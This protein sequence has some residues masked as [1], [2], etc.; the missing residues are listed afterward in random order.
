[1]NDRPARYTF[2]SSRLAGTI[3]KY[4]LAQAAPLFTYYY[5]RLARSIYSRCLSLVSFSILAPSAPLSLSLSNRTLHRIR[6]QRDDELQGDAIYL[7]I[8]R[9]RRSCSSPA[10][11]C[12]TERNILHSPALGR[13]ETDHCS[14]LASKTASSRR[15]E[16]VLRS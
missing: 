14:V 16:R 15:R 6:V 7:K 3:L 1:M 12:P 2:G 11:E 8:Q 9:Q 10:R 5:E 4:N 13:P